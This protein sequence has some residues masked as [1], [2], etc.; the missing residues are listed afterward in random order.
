MP[1]NPICGFGGLEAVEGSH[2]C[3]WFVM[4]RFSVI[5]STCMEESEIRGI[6][7][8]SLTLL[9]KLIAVR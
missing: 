7:G 5:Q 1:I 3:S 8:T 6:A 4:F 9:V 2:P